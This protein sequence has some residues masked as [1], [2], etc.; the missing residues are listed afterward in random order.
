MQARFA[1]V[2]QNFA[3]VYGSAFGSNCPKHIREVLRAKSVRGLDVSEVGIDF[4][5]SLFAIHL[6]LARHGRHQ[7]RT[8]KIHACRPAAMPP[9]VRAIVDLE[10][11]ALVNPT[12]EEVSA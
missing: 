12:L 8:F 7:A 4:Q 2:K 11:S 6:C 3:Q 10:P 1:V 9:G 5:A